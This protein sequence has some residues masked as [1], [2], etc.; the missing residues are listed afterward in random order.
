M[1]T[2]A[3]TS[4]PVAMACSAAIAAAAIPAIVC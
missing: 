4:R 3:A 1:A 2:A